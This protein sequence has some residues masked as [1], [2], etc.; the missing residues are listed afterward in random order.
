MNKNDAIAKIN[1]YGK[2]GSVI[3]VVM[4]VI[5]SIVMLI[6]LIAA[7]GLKVIPDDAFNINLGTQAEVIINPSVLDSNADAAV[8]DEVVNAI[9]NGQVQGGLNL[10]AVSMKLNT[11]EVVDN[12]VVCK[13]TEGMGVLHLAN[14][15]NVLLL[16]VVS[17]LLTLISTIFGF[18][19]CKSIEKCETPFEDNVIK[20]M[21]YL[22]YSLLPWAIFSSVP[23]YAVN[24]IFNNN[25]KINFSLDMNIILIVLVILALTVVFKYGAMLQQESDET[26]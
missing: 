2:I 19:F 3:T 14:V 4:T 7:I 16:V 9:N 22:A 10:G 23:K 13:T 5:V 6:T 12:K 1:K 25:L 17:L 21:R 24:N 26:L 15:G 20:K 18:R 8:L 11:A